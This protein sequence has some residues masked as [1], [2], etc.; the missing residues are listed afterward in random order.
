MNTAPIT[1]AGQSSPNGRPVQA[2]FN[3]ESLLLATCGG[4]LGLL[5]AGWT[6]TLLLSLNPS[7]I[8]RLSE[9]HLDWRVLGFVAALALLTG[10]VFGLLPT[11]SVT[12][13][14]L[15]DAIKEGMGRSAA[16]ALSGRLRGAL[17]MAEVALS[18]VLLIGAGLM[19]RSF[20]RLTAVDSGL[21]PEGVLTLDVSL[22]AQG[23]TEQSKRQEFVRQTIERLRAM[24]GA[25]SVASAGYVPMSG[26]NTNRRFAFADRPL[27][28]PGK[29]PFAVELPVSPDYFRVLGIPLRVGR[30]FTGQETPEAPALIVNEKF[31]ERFFPGENALGKRIRFYSASAQGQQPPFIEIVGIVGNVNHRSLA[32]GTEPM[33]Y[34]AQGAGVWG[35]MSFLVRTKGDPL[36]LAVPAR[37][38][39]AAVDKTLAV[40]RVATLEEVIAHSVEQRRG[41]MSLLGAFAAVAL[42]LAVVGIYGVLS[43]TVSQRT[44]EI[45]LRLAL[46]AQ[47]RDVLKLILAQGMKL[48]LAGVSI[49]LTVAF[50][51]TRL[52]KTLLFGISATDSLTFGVVA[53]SLLGV[54]LLA[55]WIPARRATKVDPLI[56]LRNE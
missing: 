13:N 17:V 53:L 45:G 54:A 33:I 48:A 50:G 5:L 40:S 29:E 11:L 52:M 15:A 6:R 26:V 23:Y 24:P 30:F 42:L 25:E 51:L 18:L 14:K 19:V 43:Y 34:S 56:A 22:P 38:A 36:A 35:F 32:D 16:G 47:T 8:S 41:L 28:E 21:K 55:C 12:R 2:N 39:V 7:K 27:P 10:V 1:I 46:G 31:A 37:Q 3:T 9:T 44:Q 49:G 20:I 4:V